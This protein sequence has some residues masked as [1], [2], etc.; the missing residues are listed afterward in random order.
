[1]VLYQ[2]LSNTTADTYCFSGGQRV[3]KWVS[4]CAMYKHVQS[5]TTSNSNCNSA[6]E[7]GT[8][9]KKIEI[10]ASTYIW[11]CIHQMNHQ[12]Y[13]FNGLKWNFIQSKNVTRIF[14]MR[15]WHIRKSNVLLFFLSSF[16]PSLLLGFKTHFSGLVDLVRLHDYM[17]QFLQFSWVMLLFFVFSSLFLF[18]LWRCCFTTFSILKGYQLAWLPKLPSFL[19]SSKFPVVSSSV[20]YGICSSSSY[21]FFLFCFISQCE[22]SI[23]VDV[24]VR[25]CINIILTFFSLHFCIIFKNFMESFDWVSLKLV[26]F[27]V[28]PV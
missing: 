15:E 26:V 17:R 20:I 23:C 13:L 3:T 12:T 10:L 1:M 27:L 22:A 6:S 28:T 14:D 18:F 11:I 2:W 8:T 5:N 19:R 9:K 24:F 21:S 4:V 25:T 7:A 16:S